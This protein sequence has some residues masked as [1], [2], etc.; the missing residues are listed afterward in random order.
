[1]SET[2][3]E[4]TELASRYSTQ[5]TADLERNLKE[6]E[7]LSGQIEALQAQLAAL[8]H[9]RTVLLNIQQALGI[10]APHA[11]ESV[12]AVPAPP[13]KQATASGPGKR[14]KA[15]KAA[16]QARKRT[17]KKTA[18]E[19][20]AISSTAPKLVDLVREHLAGQSEPRSAAG[21]TTALGQQ[22]PERTI[23]T[24]VVR[25]TLEGLVAKTQAQRTKQGWSV[26][27]IAPE[28]AGST[29]QGESAAEP[30]A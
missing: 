15:E 29:A 9:D 12:A 13:K 23:K 1:M 17:G 10:P 22:H 7:C 25:T 3:T 4:T 21:I 8:R 6:Q 2:I 11:A 30:S 5:V 19:T 26:F 28:T 16:A 27:Y 24:T 18:V 20:P 14:A